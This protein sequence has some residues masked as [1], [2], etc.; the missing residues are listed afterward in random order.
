[1]NKK[2]PDS[3]APFLYMIL[4]VFTTVILF[5]VKMSSELAAFMVV[6]LVIQVIAVLTTAYKGD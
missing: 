4:F 3:I 5:T 6:L 1:M 2:I